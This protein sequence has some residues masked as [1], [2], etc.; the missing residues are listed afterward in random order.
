MIL[1]TPEKSLYLSLAQQ[2]E[3]AGLQI[4]V[5]Q[6]TDRHAAELDHRMAD[7]IEHLSDL[8][9]AALVE[10]DSVPGVRGALFHQAYLRW[11]GP[12][13]AH[14]HAAFEHRNLALGR[15]HLHLDLIHLRHQLRA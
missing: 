12:F 11:R 8:L 14:G 10:R 5:L 3:L 4:F 9:I 6:E 1:A 15:L 2:P 7:V 13:A